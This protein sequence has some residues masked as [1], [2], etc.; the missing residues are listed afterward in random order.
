MT[1]ANTARI[2]DQKYRFKTVSFSSSNGL[3]HSPF[4]W[5]M[6]VRF[7][8][9]TPGSPCRTGSSFCRRAN[10]VLLVGLVDLQKPDTVAYGGDVARILEKSWAA[11]C[12]LLQ[13]WYTGGNVDDVDTEHRINR[14]V[15]GWCPGQFSTHK[16][17]LWISTLKIMNT[18]TGAFG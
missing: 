11:I 4:T 10:V 18:K 12:I 7:P 6:G 5:A 3:G 2:V 16:S 8:S 13:Y 17:V 15:R 9:R 14:P 1:D